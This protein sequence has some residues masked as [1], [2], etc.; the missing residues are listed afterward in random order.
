ML[1]RDNIAAPTRRQEVFRIAAPPFSG[2]VAVRQLL[3][4]E[5]IAAEE[6]AQGATNARL[7]PHLLA[8]AVVDAD[9]LPIWTA[10]QWDLWAVEHVAEFTRLLDTVLKVNGRA[11][12]EAKK[13]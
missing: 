12:G 6:A 10:E 11:A 13:G 9:A 3:L 7:F 5:W 8:V 2:D 1:K 4:G